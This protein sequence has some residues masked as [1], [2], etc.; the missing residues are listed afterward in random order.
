MSGFFFPR[1]LRL[2]SKADFDRV[3]GRRKSV[4]DDVLI[5]YGRENDA[6]HPRL[7]LS[8]SRK[9]GGAVQRNLWKRRIRAAFRESQHELPRAV[10]LVVSPRRRSDAS[11]EAIRASLCDL[12]RRVERK[13]EARRS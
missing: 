7:G 3:Y 4:A 11:Y 5:V 1:A 12:A 6:G 2:R 13:L 8:V 9:V 10:D